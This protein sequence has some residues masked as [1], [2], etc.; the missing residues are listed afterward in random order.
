VAI[1]SAICGVKLLSKANIERM[2]FKK[3]YKKRAYRKKRA[4]K[5]RSGYGA[6]T[7]VPKA[8]N[9]HTFKRKCRLNTIQIPNLSNGYQAFG[10]TFNLNQLPNYTELTVLYDSYRINWV[11]LYIVN[12][13]N[14]TTQNENSSLAFGSPWM[15][16]VVDHDDATAPASSE[17][18]MD[19]LRE[20]KNAKLKFFSPKRAHSIMIKPAILY[21][22]YETAL[23]SAYTAKQG[24]WVDCNYFPPQYGLKGIVNVPLNSGTM[25]YTANFDVFATFSVSMKDPR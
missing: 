12:R 24:Q 25:P 9:I 18:G 8:S 2:P 3:T 1:D 19:T 16:Y 10:Y 17:A 15:I 20:C 22:S 11:K 6:I 21:Q 4:F 23:T 7:R 5:R 13:F 14:V